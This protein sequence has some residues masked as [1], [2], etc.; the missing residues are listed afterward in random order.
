MDK[1]KKILVWVWLIAKLVFMISAIIV[2]IK[3]IV[4]LIF[5]LLPFSMLTFSPFSSFDWNP[6]STIFGSIVT[7]GIAWFAV[8]K[9]SELDKKARLYEY[10]YKHYISN[11][12]NLNELLIPLLQISFFFKKDED[13]I[14]SKN[15][16]NDF[17]N[18]DF[19]IRRFNKIYNYLCKINKSFKT[20]TQNLENALAE[21]INIY[22]FTQRQIMEHRWYLEKND[23]R[24]KKDFISKI[25]KNN[26]V[27]C[28]GDLLNF[29]KK[30]KG[31][32]YNVANFEEE[33]D[34]L[35]DVIE[36]EF[37]LDEK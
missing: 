23:T 10:R 21:F 24:Y 16:N 37:K 9:T 13:C 26:V 29:Y 30:E 17:F 22:Q 31:I 32:E 33:I 14:I 25:G 8:Y 6:I 34:N 20:K 5:P 11:L 27:F 7:G 36:T 3:L 18:K 2:G 12:N 4:F 28:V 1:L 19:E 35:R 15:C